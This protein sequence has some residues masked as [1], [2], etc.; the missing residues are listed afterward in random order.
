VRVFARLV[1]ILFLRTVDRAERRIV[2]PVTGEL[3]P[4]RFGDVAILTPATTK[5]PLLFPELDRLGIPY[6]VRGSKLFLEDALH[7]QFLL[8]LRHLA[9]P[10]DGVAKAALFRAPFFSI[11]THR[12]VRKVTPHSPRSA[13][14][15]SG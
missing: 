15:L 3:R 11:V 9:D 5:L 6:A 13:S 4:V 1:G 10:A 8:A 14:S 7:R 2:D 12:F